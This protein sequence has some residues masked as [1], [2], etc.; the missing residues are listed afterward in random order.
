MN[1]SLLSLLKGRGWVDSLCAGE[2][3]SASDFA[4]FEVQMALSEEGDGKVF[5][6]APGVTCVAGPP[7]RQPV[8]PDAGQKRKSRHDVDDDGLTF[9]AHGAGAA[10]AGPSKRLKGPQSA[11][12]DRRC[13]YMQQCSSFLATCRCLGCL[14]GGWCFASTPRLICL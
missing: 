6:K 7:K 2:S 10:A 14:A 1:R 8:E 4:M 13:G 12:V 5:L 3:A 11:P 9:H